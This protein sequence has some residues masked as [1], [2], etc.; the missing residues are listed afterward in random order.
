MK[1]IYVLLFILCSMA[2]KSQ[3]IFWY[4]NFG[5]GTTCGA[6]QGTL[7]NGFVSNNGTWVVTNQ[8]TNDL[9]AN[10][11]YVSQTEAG[12]I[13]GLCGVNCVDSPQVV[14][15]TLHVANLPGSP[16]SVFCP[17]GDC[18][19]NYDPGMGNNSVRTNKRVESP[20]I[21][22]VGK[23]G[24]TVKFD[25]ILRGN[26]GDSAVFWY[27][28]GAAW[29]IIGNPIPATTTCSPTA[30]DTT[31]IWTTL[32]YPLPATAN[33]NGAVKIG[34]QWINNDDGK[35]GDPALAVDNIE[36][37]ANTLGGGPSTLTVTII[38]PDTVNPNPIYCTN[39]PYHFTGN[40]NP[41]PI[42]FYDW[43]SY[44]TLASNATF[45]P[46]PPYQNGVNVT[47][48]LPGTYTLVLTANSQYNGIDSNQIVINVL[49]TPTVTV[50]PTYPTVC[51]NG[52]GTNLYA[53]GASTYTWTSTSPVA[54]PTYLDANGDSVWVNPTAVPSNLVTYTVVGTST[55]G[56][57]SLP[58]PI[59]V[60]VIA[61]PIPHYA[62]APDTICNGSHSILS[63]T[64][65]PVSATYTWSAPFTGGLGTN[66]GSSAQVTPIYTGVV[67]T[68][69][70][71]T[72]NVNVPGCPTYSATTI[73]VVVK[74]T[75]VVTSLTDTSG[76]CN[77][78][79]A[80][81]SATST[82][83][84]ANTTYSW[85]P[86]YHL[87]ST[88]GSTVTATPTV[89]TKYYVTSNLNGC[90]S[91]KDSVQVLIGDTTAASISSEYGIICITQTNQ[92]IA[93]PQNGLLNNSY[94]YSWLPQPLVSSSIG[95]DTVVVQP[96]VSTIYTLTVHGTCVKHNVA[97]FGI[98]VN[99]CTPPK[100]SFTANTHTICV[101]HCITFKDS[102]QYTSTKPL[103]YSWVFV[104]GSI[105]P[106]TGS[107]INADTLFYNMTDTLP[108]GPVK[109]CYH[110]NSLL[111]VNGYF[112]VIETVKNGIGQTESFIDSVRVDPGPQA[113]AGSN[114]TINEGTPT[115][116][117]G[118][119]STGYAQINS[120][121]W[122]QSDFGAMSC[123]HCESPVVTPTTTTDYTLTI[124][125]INGC[126]STSS[127]TVFVDVV[128][129]DVFVANAFSP[130]GDGLND[131]LHVKSNCDMINMS[132]KIFDR[133]GEKVFESTDLSY[134]WDGTF[135]NKPMDSAVFMYTLDGF[136]ST[137]KEVKQKGNITL[138]R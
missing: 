25:H 94:Y 89:A 46:N 64:N 114:Q 35:G 68:T 132:F 61:A 65:L 71:Y 15:R 126:A 56:C 138:M 60:T 30:G 131:V 113:N 80:L 119:G 73:K 40:V 137:G 96:S 49:Q 55:G 28:D 79:G 13:A 135:R 87:S 111:N 33:N 128:C 14:N 125:D 41:G 98:T 112:P 54:P 51:L 29:S 95:G 121:S 50:S 48:P 16:N 69:F 100:V 31:G 59:T 116:L 18:G 122:T 102:T 117:T 11:W 9:Y 22:C 39:T 91:K 62:A 75:P 83:V 3:T 57:I 1:N 120:Y 20:V 32:V 70:V 82:P 130:N 2:L 81:L 133:W 44:T 109:V 74:P 110:T 52:T 24:I 19:A 103:F 99:N 7:A 8:G 67:D 58:K 63:V 124:T 108:L 97:T 118:A 21:S 53:T 129:K 76:N 12:T 92:L 66:S 4:E 45:N 43:T 104:G 86:N 84:N 42:L 106:V 107:T 115:T 26:T 36:V 134:G 78:M 72:S 5:V 10:V 17:T 23:A 123:T 88:T 34:F 105:T 27:F 127:V 38:P 101:N 77:G 6:N 93:Y 90:T 136:L 47:F 85:T 37:L